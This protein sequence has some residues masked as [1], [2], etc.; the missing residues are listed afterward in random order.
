MSWMRKL[1]FDGGRNGRNEIITPRSFSGA[2]ASKVQKPQSITAIE[3]TTEPRIFTPSA[4]LNRVLG[5]GIVRGSLVLIGE[6]R[7]SES[8]LYKPNLR[9]VS[10][11]TK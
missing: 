4:E 9:A 11:E 7:V 6:I 5:G 2:T 10:N 3:S 8:L 1:E